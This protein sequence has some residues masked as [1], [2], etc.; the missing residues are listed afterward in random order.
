MSPETILSVVFTNDKTCA[1][2]HIEFNGY[3]VECL[4]RL[5]T[6]VRI[7]AIKNSGLLK[8]NEQVLIRFSE[9]AGVRS[10]ELKNLKKVVHASS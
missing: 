1:H 10:T 6:Q 7:H 3:E 2:D 8:K 4:G 5:K 9:M